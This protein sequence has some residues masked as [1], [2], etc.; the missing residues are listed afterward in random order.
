M[1]DEDEAVFVFRMRKI[2]H[3]E[4]GGWMLWNSYS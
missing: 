3:G 1:N 4:R 2:I